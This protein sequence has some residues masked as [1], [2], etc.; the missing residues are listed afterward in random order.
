[1]STTD[2]ISNNGEK[3]TPDEIRA[4]IDA[5]RAGLGFDVDA[6]ADKV[7]PTQVAHR[8]VEKVKSQFTNAKESVFGAVHDKTNSTGNASDTAKQAG[9]QAAEK[10]KGNPLAVG[11]L[12]FGAGWLVSS[13][14]PAT[15]KEQAFAGQ[16][17]EQ[18][19]P[20]V[21]QAKSAAQDVAQNL[22][23]PAQDA[24]A[25]VKDTAQDAA[26]TVKDEAQGAASNVKDSAQGSADEVK[27]A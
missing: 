11:L 8:Q 4:E 9:Q 21:D 25:S 15:E 3:K 18:A 14:I 1:M 10:V 16:V 23:G 2:G 13:L 20:L 24:V 12:A 22:K 26:G 6:L 5:T 27:N 17:K 7:D 19:A